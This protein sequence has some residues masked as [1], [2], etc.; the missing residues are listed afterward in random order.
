[1]SRFF[2]LQEKNLSLAQM[3]AHRSFLDVD[4]D[5]NEIYADGICAVDTVTKSFGG[6]PESEVVVFD[7]QL[8][9]RIYD[10][11]VVTPVKIVARFSYN[12][13]CDMV[14][15]ETAYDYE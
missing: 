4:Q 15:D 12:K 14:D 10:G 5:G 6:S 8:V 9:E 13:W 7:G 11:V 1:M 2:R 3:Q